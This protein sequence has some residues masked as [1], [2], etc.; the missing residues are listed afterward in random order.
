MRLPAPSTK[1]RTFRPSGVHCTAPLS[2]KR[3]VVGGGQAMTAPASLPTTI[4]D[5]CMVPQPALAAA[6]APPFFLAPDLDDEEEEAAAAA[7]ATL[8]PPPEAATQEKAT[9][10]PPWTAPPAGRRR[11]ARLEDPPPLPSVVTAC[12]S[13]S[14]VPRIGY[15]SLC[16][17]R[18]NR[19]CAPVYGVHLTMR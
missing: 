13:T 9:A 1:P 15:F 7:A 17:S 5:V 18:Q 4:I 8:P 10:V 19:T 12:R 11:P 14:R 16:F 3:L 6:A 2:L